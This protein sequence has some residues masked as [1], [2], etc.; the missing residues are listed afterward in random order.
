MKNQAVFDRNGYVR[1][2]HKN[3]HV[4]RRISHSLNEDA[5]SS[6]P[7]ISWVVKRTGRIDAG[8]KDARVKTERTSG[9]MIRD[10]RE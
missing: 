2:P 6:K 5:I 3:K 9:R 7:F 1:H 10:E 8:T 4:E